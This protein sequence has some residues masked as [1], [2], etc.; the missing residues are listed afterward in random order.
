MIDFGSLYVCW[1]SICLEGAKWIEF[2]K[3]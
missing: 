2:L 1:F 3:F